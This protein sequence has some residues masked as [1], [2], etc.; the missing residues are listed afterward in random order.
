MVLPYGNASK[1]LVHFDY[2]MQIY[3]SITNDVSNN[4]KYHKMSLNIKIKLKLA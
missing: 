2:I 3:S 4:D 1:I